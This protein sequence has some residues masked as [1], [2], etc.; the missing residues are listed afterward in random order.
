[1]HTAD[2]LAELVNLSVHGVDI[3]PNDD[4]SLS[5]AARDDEQRKA[6]ASSPAPVAGPSTAKA[7]RSK[8]AAETKK[9]AE[10]TKNQKA[11]DAKKKKADKANKAPQKTRK[12]PTPRGGKKGKGKAPTL[13]EDETLGDTDEERNARL[14]EEE[15]I[16]IQT[17]ESIGQYL[18]SQS[19]QQKH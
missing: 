11:E 4:L 7:T 10:D 18:L 1:M 17:E 8:T 13:R 5:W 14:D 9:K 2:H 12:A 6:Q 16:R 15:E 3:N 19:H